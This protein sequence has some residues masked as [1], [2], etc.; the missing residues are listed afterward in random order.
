MCTFVCLFADDG[1]D[2]CKLLA[3]KNQRRKKER[4]EVNKTF[5]RRGEEEGRDAGSQWLVSG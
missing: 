5:L 2:A 3:C 1:T 4:E